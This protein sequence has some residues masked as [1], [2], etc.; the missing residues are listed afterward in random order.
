LK[1]S[2]RRA[3][4]MTATGLPLD[5]TVTT[6]PVATTRNRLEKNRLASVAEMVFIL[7]SVLIKEYFNSNLNSLIIELVFSANE[8]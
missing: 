3:A 7:N 1:A 2:S 6:S 4:E 5:I 8:F